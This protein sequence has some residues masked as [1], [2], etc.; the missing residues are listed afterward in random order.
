MAI[1]YSGISSPSSSPNNTILSGVL[2]SPKPYLPSIAS[3]SSASGL[4]SV[5]VKDILSFKVLVNSYIFARE[6]ATM[7]GLIE[8]RTLFDY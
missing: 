3:Q 2:S 8:I 4:V 7:S 6:Y 5:V 1:I